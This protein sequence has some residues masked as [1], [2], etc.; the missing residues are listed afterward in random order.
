MIYNITGSHIFD[1][2][3]VSPMPVFFK[4]SLEQIVFFLN[5]KGFDISSKDYEWADSIAHVDTGVY[6]ATATLFCRNSNWEMKLNCTQREPFF[7]PE[8]ITNHFMKVNNID[9]TVSIHLQYD[10]GQTESKIWIDVIIP[11]PIRDEFITFL[12]S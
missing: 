9:H 4:R 8:Y 11:D 6:S 10:E 2:A 7:M 5:S 1:N 12:F 3:W